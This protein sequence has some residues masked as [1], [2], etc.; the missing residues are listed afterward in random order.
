MLQYMICKYAIVGCANPLTFILFYVMLTQ[1]GLLML[2][3]AVPPLPKH[4][5]MVYGNLTVCYCYGATMDTVNFFFG[6]YYFHP[7][8]LNNIFPT[9]LL[10]DSRHIV[11]IPSCL[12]SIGF[13]FNASSSI[14][15][16]QVWTSN[17]HWQIIRT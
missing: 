12:I 11:A 3:L 4:I 10:M 2:I 7:P 16:E 9:P 13:A 15:C 1:V 17:N 6:M 5:M 14:S 8:I